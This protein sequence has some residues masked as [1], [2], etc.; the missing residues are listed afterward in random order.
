MGDKV[1]GLPPAQ[2]GFYFGAPA[3]GYFLGNFISGRFSIRI[4]VNRMVYWGTVINAAGI[5]ANLALFYAGLGT[6]I[7]FFGFMCFMG[8]GNGMTIP[9][10]TAGALSVRPH[11]AGT[12]S[13]LAGALMIGGGAALSAIAGATLSAETGAFPLLWIMLATALLAVAAI[14]LTMRRE[15][16]LALQ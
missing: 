13:G 12:A 8:L 16:R 5:A 3:I 15:R 11:L 2:L 9:N 4:G 14:L 1:F 10:A 6:A 7:S